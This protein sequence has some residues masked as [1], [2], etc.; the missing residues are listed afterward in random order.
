MLTEK[1]LYDDEE[2]IPL[3]VLLAR[4]N[5]ARKKSTNKKSSM[6]KSPRSSAKKTKRSYTKSECPSH[7]GAEP[8]NKHDGCKWNVKKDKCYKK[9]VKRSSNP[10]DEHV[11]KYRSAHPDKDLKESLKEASKTYK[12]R[13]SVVSIPEKD[14]DDMLY[15]EEDADDIPLGVLYAKEIAEHK[16][17]SSK[18]RKVVNNE[19]KGNNEWNDYVNEYRRLN[20]GLSLKDALKIA[21][22]T[23]KKKQ[24]KTRRS[25]VR[26]ECPS[27][28]SSE[29]CN[30]HDGCKWNSKKEKCHKKKN[31]T[32][33]P[34]NI[35]AYE[36]MKYN[37]NLS[38][39]DALKIAKS[40]Y[41]RMQ[42]N[43]Q[44]DILHYMRKLHKPI[45]TSEKTEKLVKRYIREYSKL[46]NISELDAEDELREIF[47]AMDSE[48]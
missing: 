47:I 16:K 33:A 35:Y 45:K 21:K 26:S 39:K 36:Y 43:S 5:S 27:H 15:D 14:I 20:P 32:N 31:S 24:V 17:R 23:Y 6:K 8:C 13:S 2:D 25:Y 18:K 30:K 34:W 48:Q 11:N 38:L 10:W 46:N 1:P 3:G 22:T 19:K 7:K 42:P 9:Y 28:S 4:Q 41:K 29:T 12:R 37:P 40:I 44:M